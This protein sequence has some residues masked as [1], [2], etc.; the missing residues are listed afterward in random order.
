M[1]KNINSWDKKIHYFLVFLQIT[2]YLVATLNSYLQI[3]STLKNNDSM[4]IEPHLMS[5]RA[6]ANV[7]M[8]HINQ[9]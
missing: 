9:Y 4:G 2:F 8:G 3:Q 5:K 6:S 1:M 7:K